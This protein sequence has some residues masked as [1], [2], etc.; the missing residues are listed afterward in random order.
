MFIVKLGMVGQSI[1][2]GVVVGFEWRGV[3][4]A[5]REQLFSFEKRGDFV[6][7]LNVVHHIYWSVNTVSVAPLI[8]STRR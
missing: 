1:L 4:P 8:V 2:A 6:L 7:S 3:N 5:K